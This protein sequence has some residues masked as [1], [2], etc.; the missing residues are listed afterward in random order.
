V[1][2][3]ATILVFD[4]DAD[5][6]SSIAAALRRDGFDVHPFADPKEGLAHLA[7]GSSG[8]TRPFR[9]SS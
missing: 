2:E 4:D 1:K 5:S 3:K 6:L 9:S 8:K 7:S